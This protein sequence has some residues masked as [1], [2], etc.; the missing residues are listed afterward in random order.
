M[1]YIVLQ[2]FKIFRT[3]ILIFLFHSLTEKNSAV[4]LQYGS[5]ITICLGKNLINYFLG[6][7][8]IF[9]LHPV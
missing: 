2:I 9:M 1:S 6:E 8:N 5:K 3:D 7:T 4:F